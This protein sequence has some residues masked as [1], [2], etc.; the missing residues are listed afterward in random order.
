MRRIKEKYSLKESLYGYLFILPG[1]IGFLV[2]VLVPVISSLFLSF[3]EWDFISGLSTIKLIG[4]ENYTKLLGDEW[5]T[6]SFRNNLVFTLVSIPIT[7]IISLVI[8][9]LILDIS[10]FKNGIKVMLFVPYISSIVAVCVVWMVLLHPS[11]GPINEMLYALGVED[12]PKWL[13]SLDWSLPSIIGIYIWQQ[14]G[15]FVVVYIAGLS[16]IPEE[17]YESA[18]IDGAGGLKK[19]FYITIPMIS[20][21]TFFL[22]TM[23]MI[24]SFKVFDHISVMTQGGPG[25]ST[26]VLAYYIYKTAFEYYKM[27]YASSISWVLFILVFA[28]TLVQWRSQNKWVNY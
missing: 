19:F 27:G 16:G 14:I 2:F 26:T 17:L 18:A 25:T 22:V 7:T 4:I 12:P 24:G 20:P 15:Y 21:T 11:Y 10:Y 13:A 3:S 9:A 6:S 8:A 1:L 28:V 23:G 5:F